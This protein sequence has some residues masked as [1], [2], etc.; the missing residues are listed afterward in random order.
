MTQFNN[1]ESDIG[2]VIANR[3]LF[4][5]P[6]S[7]FKNTKSLPTPNWVMS[8]KVAGLWHKGK[9][10]QALD[11]HYEDLVRE[12]TGGQSAYIGV[13]EIDAVTG[14]SLIQCKRSKAALLNPNSF[15]KGARKQIKRTIAFAKKQNKFAEFWF[16]SSAAPIVRE[17]IESH[18]G[19]FKSG[20]DEQSVVRYKK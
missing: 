13:Y 9:K 20:L 16:E 10:K 2:E 15:I 8:E 3:S 5:A 12:K 7:F 19:V 11:F 14:Q 1:V 17:Y 6:I 18:G 4:N